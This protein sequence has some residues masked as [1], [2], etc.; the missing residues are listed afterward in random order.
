MATEEPAERRVLGRQR[1]ASKAVVRYVGSPPKPAAE[2]AVLGQF[3]HSQYQSK[4]DIALLLVLRN[5]RAMAQASQLRREELVAM[6]RQAFAFRQQSLVRQTISRLREVATR[7]MQRTD[8]Q[9]E[10]V[11][12]KLAAMH[13]RQLLLGRVV[14]RLGQA[15]SLQRRLHFLQMEHAHKAM[16]RCWDKWRRLLGQRRVLALEEAAATVG[17]RSEQRLVAGALDRWRARTDE[18]VAIARVVEERHGD[19]VLRHTLHVWHML[20]LAVRFAQ[21]Q[22]AGPV[23]ATLVRWRDAAGGLRQQ[24]AREAE[25]ARLAD[26]D[27]MVYRADEHY[28]KMLMWSALNQLYLARDYYAASKMAA[29][30]FCVTVR[31][32]RALAEWRQHSRARR[33]DVLQSRALRD[34]EREHNRKQRHVLLLAWHKIAIDGRRH[35]RRADLLTARRTSA[36][37]R[38]CLGRWADEYRARTTTAL[39]AAT[40]AHVDAQTMTSFQAGPPERPGSADRPGSAE[41]RELIQRARRAEYEATRARALL[42]GSRRES[43]LA[44]ATHDELL[45]ELAGQWQQRARRRQLRAVL[46]QMG[47]AAGRARRERA[48]L[49]RKLAGAEA[50]LHDGQLRK[51]LRV[52][53]SRAQLTV[54]QTA[55]ADA[56]CYDCSSLPNRDLLA[57]AL[58]RWRA[59]LKELRHLRMAADKTR[60]VRMA[61]RLFDILAARRV[62]TEQMVARANDFW[63][64]MQLS[65][66][67]TAVIQEAQR[68]QAARPQRD[69]ALPSDRDALQALD[70]GA[71]GVLAAPA[72]PAD[73]SINDED[74]DNSL[75]ETY[76]SAWLDLVKEMQFLQGPLIERL[77]RTLQRRAL[78]TAGDFEWG[79]LHSKHLM[80]GCIVRWR[81]LAAGRAELAAD[82]DACDPRRMAQLQAIEARVRARVQRGAAKQTLRRWM[83]VMRGRLLEAQQ[84]R[85]M[86]AH[87]VAVVVA[88]ARQVAEARR[89]ERE[90][91]LRMAVQQWWAR[92][93]MVQSRLESAAVQADGTLARECVLRWAGRTHSHRESTRGRRLYT[94][95]VAFR[96]EKQAR[97]ALTQWMRRSSDC[98]V[99]ARLAQRAG[100]RRELQLAAVADQWRRERTVRGALDRLRAAAR[101]H[102]LQQE[103]LMR[104]A[105]AWGDA[106]TQRH[107]LAAWRS[108]VSPPGSM[109][110]SVVGAG[111]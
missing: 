59:R 17:R 36:V 94:K 99:R 7:R 100:P 1:A 30:N 68:R 60:A 70:F 65:N 66:A 38:D 88:R 47:A 15:G 95:A 56:L 106:N 21:S 82:G 42:I 102:A 2:E 69:R 93:Y 63:R 4:R 55:H 35:E 50:R 84:P 108:C 18:P 79:L 13:H 29:D 34:W 78:E 48:Q 8:Y 43:V 76:F 25:R 6:W 74:I 85:N 92:L 61:R 81:R 9:Y 111:D 110:F 57:R 72:A 105:A 23:Q 27:E 98:R 53:R 3:V 49:E 64:T 11:Q 86:L 51:A 40:L 73:A 26:E 28:R 37:V 19:R 101:R 45:E 58:R 83:V 71:P 75:L 97:R 87:V 41:R 89:L 31:K 54:R 10:Q 103:M 12:H 91:L 67:W 16:Y 44:R 90:R 24:R 62:E 96:W 39:P 80:R 107:A 109:F 46:G 22:R 5:W 20:A 52:W 32:Y 77:P 104:F 33:S 14:D